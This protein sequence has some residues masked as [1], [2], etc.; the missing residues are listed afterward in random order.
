VLRQPLENGEITISRSL[1]S[2][3][4]PAKFMLL[5]AMN[6]CEDSIG[7]K[8]ADY[9]NCTPSQKRRYYSRISKPLLDRIDLQIEVKKV[10]IEE[11]TSNTRCESSVDIKQRVVQAR[12]IQLERFKNLKKKMLFANGQMNN[13]EIKKFCVLDAESE[14]LL[15]M[16]VERLNMSAR[17]YFKILKISR[18]IAD[19]ERNEHIKVHHIQEALQY[20]SLDFFNL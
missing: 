3:T 8:D 19:L 20:R 5:G 1:T 7:I 9:Y 13:K 18:T 15:K 14:K 10:N 6:P 2:Y 16:A 17:S 12:N 11:I 4:Y